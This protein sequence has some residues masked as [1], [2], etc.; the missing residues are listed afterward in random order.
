MAYI[1]TNFSDLS[2]IFHSFLTLNPH[3]HGRGNKC[4]INVFRKRTDS[5]NGRRFNVY[6][7]RRKM[8]LSRQPKCQLAMDQR[9]ISAIATR[10]C[11]LALP[12]SMTASVL[13]VTPTENYRCECIYCLLVHM[14]V[15][16]TRLFTPCMVHI[17]G[18]RL[19]F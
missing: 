10:N 9:T 13:C 19:L 17:K 12:I 14:L 16:V 4:L 11:G 18:Y 5:K 2:A 15:A 8:N 7:T 1:I 3:R 6:P